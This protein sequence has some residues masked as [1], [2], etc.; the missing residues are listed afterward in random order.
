LDRRLDIGHRPPDIGDAG[1]FIACPMLL[2]NALDR[3]LNVRKRRTARKQAVERRKELAWGEIK[4]SLYIT[5]GRRVM[6][7]DSNTKRLR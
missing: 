5:A 1:E 3:Q 4:E 2:C 7:D 6:Q